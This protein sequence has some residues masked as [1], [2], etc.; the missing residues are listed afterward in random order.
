MPWLRRIKLN[1]NAA[2]L[3]M[4]ALWGL[5]G[6]AAVTVDL[7]TADS[8][9][10]LGA[11]A[12]T[13]TGPTILNGNLGVWPTGAITGFPPGIVNGTTHLAD[14]VAQQA[15]IDLS[16]AY[17]SAAAQGCD[18]NLASELGGLTLLPGV[19][20][21]D[22]SA[23]LTNTLTLDA[24]NDPTSVFIFKIPFTLTTASA[25]SV[26][27]LNQ[28]QGGSVY[29]LVGSSATLG[30]TTDFAGNILAQASITMN[31]GATIDCGRA[32][33]LTG[34]VTLDTNTISTDSQGCL[35]TNTSPTAV[36][37]PNTAGLL[38]AGLILSTILLLRRRLLGAVVGT[39]A[40]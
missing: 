36:P 34:A 40:N 21:F 7:G 28:G 2:R 27:F 5:H 4:V 23:G 1:C 22:D 30:T 18:Q 12:V 26:L 39:A 13:N 3:A 25:S 24:M 16:S 35:S 19:Y 17:N 15:Q 14:A 29:W 10:V 37:E 6:S 33:A 8:F 31:T 20:C 38:G 11:S 32:L 9:A